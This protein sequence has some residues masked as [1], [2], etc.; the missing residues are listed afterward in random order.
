ML[1]EETVVWNEMPKRLMF[2]EPEAFLPRQRQ[3]VSLANC[4]GQRHGEFRD[5]ELVDDVNSCRPPSP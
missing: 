1:Q 4:L 3:I 2:D 5:Q